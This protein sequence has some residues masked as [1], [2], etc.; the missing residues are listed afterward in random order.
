MVLLLKHFAR[1]FAGFR[2]AK[3]MRQQCSCSRDLYCDQVTVL[4]SPVAD[5]LG[6]MLIQVKSN[7]PT[8][9]RMK[10]GMLSQRPLSRSWKNILAED[11]STMLAVGSRSYINAAAN[12]LKP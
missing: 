2:I 12:E 11:T 3:R 1:T 5:Q 6:K 10:I 4:K 9:A 8:S 7:P